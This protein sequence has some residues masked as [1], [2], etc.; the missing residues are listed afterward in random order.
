MRVLQRLGRVGVVFGSFSVASYFALQ[1]GSG[2]LWKGFEPA[3][4]VTSKDVKAPYDLTRLDAVNET[5]RTIRDKYVDPS[6]VKPKEMLLSA[7]N[8]VQRETIS[9]L[10]CRECDSMLYT[11]SEVHV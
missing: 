5:L 11:K 8:F 3:L 4:A 7:L 10:N 1:F 6:R 9:K 2:G